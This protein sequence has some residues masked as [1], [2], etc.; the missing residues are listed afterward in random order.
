M[1]F[2]YR[3][4][5]APHTVTVHNRAIIQSLIYPYHDMNIAQ[6]LLSGGSIPGIGERFRGGKYTTRLPA[7]KARIPVV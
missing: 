4:G 7:E 3:L 2:G 5:T 6:L 1:G